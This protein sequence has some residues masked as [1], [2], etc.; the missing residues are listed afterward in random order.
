M[1]ELQCNYR[2]N[3]EIGV[4]SID[5]EDFF[6]LVRLRYNVGEPKYVTVYPKIIY[7]KVPP[8]NGL[9]LTRKRYSIPGMK[10]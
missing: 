5:I 1:F 4:N 6:G 8:Q 9:R 3:Y 10:T 2:G 7:R